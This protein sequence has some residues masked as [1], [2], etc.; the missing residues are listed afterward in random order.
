M[1]ITQ[2]NSGQDCGQSD[3]SDKNAQKNEAHLGH[4]GLVLFHT[5]VH[6]LIQVV[7]KRIESFY[8]VFR[9]GRVLHDLKGE[10]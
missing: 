9:A 5:L 6:G 7:S 2:N 3:N 10:I 4:L 8:F 1:A